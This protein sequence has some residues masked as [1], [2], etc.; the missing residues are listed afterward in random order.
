MAP[1]PGG[2]ECGWERVGVRVGRGPQIPGRRHT[3]GEVAAHPEKS[4]QIPR[5]SRTSREVVAHPETESHIPRRSRTSGDGAVHPEKAPHIRR[6]SHTSREVAPHPETEPHIW[7]SRPTSADGAIHLE[8]SPHIPRRSRTS[9]EGAV[10][11]EKASR[12]WRSRR[13]SADGAMDLEKSPQIPRRRGAFPG[14]A[15]TSG[16]FGHSFTARNYAQTGE[17]PSSFPSLHPAF[18]ALSSTSFS[19]FFRCSSGGWP[20]SGGFFDIAKQQSAGGRHPRLCLS[21]L[22]EPARGRGPVPVFLLCAW[23]R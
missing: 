17:A 7:R 12:I 23:A 19:R 14:S 4:P 5:R 2:R 1:S 18:H 20:E 3:S 8:K 21:V 16:D 13:A 9:G 6:R 15:T 22:G 11:P 10:H